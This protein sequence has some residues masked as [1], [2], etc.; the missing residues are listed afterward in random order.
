VDDQEVIRR[1][2]VLEPKLGKVSDR[3]LAKA[4]KL[5]TW[6]VSRHRMALGIAAHKRAPM[7][8][9][10]IVCTFVAAHPDAGLIEISEGTKIPQMK[11]R[12]VLPRLVKFGRLTAQS[13][14]RRA[15]RG[16]LPLIYRVA[17]V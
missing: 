10:T 5:S 4:A 12:E 17:V 15:L 9:D 16:P 13:G 14:V 2:K 3:A 8:R 1:L 7:D 6:R 11:L